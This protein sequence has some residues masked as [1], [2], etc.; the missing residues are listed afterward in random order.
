M[1][2]TWEWIK[3]WGM[4]M[5]DLR[6]CTIKIIC[7]QLSNLQQ[8]PDLKDFVKI[9]QNES[10][11]YSIRFAMNGPEGSPWNG[12][13]M[14]GTI[15]FPSNYPH[16]P[17]DITFTSDV[18]HPNVYP[19]NGKICLSILNTHPDQFNYFDKDTLW[20]PVIN[21]SQIFI[22]LQNLFVE[23]NLESPA[24]VDANSIYLK[25]N[26]K[27]KL[28]FAQEIHK[29]FGIMPVSGTVKEEDDIPIADG[30]DDLEQ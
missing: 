23:P 17:P 10:N 22:I 1:V 4:F 15:V 14:N 8:D 21:V 6:R 3:W 11:L 30:E 26:S 28:Y 13:V 25:D 18:F 7:K 5:Y 2:S 27:N 9:V 24:N 29:R 20:T 16:A 19:E 12:C